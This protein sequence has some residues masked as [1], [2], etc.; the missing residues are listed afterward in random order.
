MTP[1]FLT[2]LIVVLGA[3]ETEALSRAEGYAGLVGHGGAAG[4][5]SGVDCPTNI[6]VRWLAWHYFE[7]PCL[8]DA[9][10]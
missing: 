1:G 6:T 10:V 2:A 4:V 9:Y 5:P 8:L 7:V 3:G